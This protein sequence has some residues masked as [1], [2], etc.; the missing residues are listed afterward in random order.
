MKHTAIYMFIVAAVIS[1]VGC[2]GKTDSQQLRGDSTEVSFSEGDSV[3]YG[4]AGSEC[5]DSVLDLIQP[6]EDPQHFSTVKA[7]RNGNIIGNFLTGDRVAVVLSAD[8]KRVLR[9]IDISSLIGRWVTGDSIDDPASHGFNLSE[10][11]YASTISKK[12]TSCSI[13]VGT[14]AAHDLCLQNATVCLPTR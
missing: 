9:A 10:D 6:P 2:G 12:W 3:V 1:M 11:G 14:Y 4:Y 5:T 8:K 7:R 13:K